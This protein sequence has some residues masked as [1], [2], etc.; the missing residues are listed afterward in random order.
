MTSS[1]SQLLQNFYFYK[2]RVEFIAQADV[3]INKW[4]HIKF[5]G[6]IG[7]LMKEYDE[8]LYLEVFKSDNLPAQLVISPAD[9]D[10]NKFFDGDSIT[11][12]FTL[13]HTDDFWVMKFFNFLEDLNRINFFGIEIFKKSFKAFRSI[14]GKDKPDQKNLFEFR[15]GF[16]YFQNKN[17]ELP[18]I[19][20]I[21]F[22]TPAT[23]RKN[24]L[25][26]TDISPEDL[27]RRIYKRIAGLYQSLFDNSF[28]FNF[29]DIEQKGKLVGNHLTF[30][31]KIIHQKKDYTGILGNMFMKIPPSQFTS[32]LLFIGSNLHIGNMTGG[33]NGAFSFEVAPVCKLHQNFRKKL[34]NSAE[35]V[36]SQEVIDRFENL[37]YIPFPMKQVKIPKS[38]G[39]FRNL[40]IPDKTD[41]ELQKIMAEVL[42]DFYNPHFLSQ[43]YAYQKGKSAKRAINQIQKWKKE[44]PEA[45]IVRCDID[46]FFDSIPINNLLSKL[47]FTSRDFKICHFIELWLRSA[48]VKKDAYAE[49]TEGIPQGS[50]L[51]PVLSNMYLHQLDEFINNRISPY[52]IRYADDIL[53][54]LKDGKNP[55]E[56]L[57]KIKDFIGAKLSL[58][59]NQ[60]FKIGT[61][62]DPFTFL[63][64]NLW[65]KNQLSVSEEKIWSM[66]GKVRNCLAVDGIGE[67]L[68]EHIIGLRRYYGELLPEDEI[69]R[70]D[71]AVFKVYADYCIK[72]NKKDKTPDI[73]LL[74]TNGLLN[75]RNT[76]LFNWEIL[77]QKSNSVITKT[78]K[79]KLEIQQKRN[80]K[81]VSSQYELVINKPGS[82]LGKNKSKIRV[83]VKGKTLS[84][85]PFSQIKHIC[86]MAPGVGLSS[87]VSQ[88]CAKK[89]I[90]ISFF[91]KV[92]ECYMVQH[93]DFERNSEIIELQLNLSQTRKQKF[94]LAIVKNKVNNQLKLLKYYNKYYRK[95]AEL[96]EKLNQKILEISDFAENELKILGDIPVNDLFI[97]EARA[98]GYYWQGF[99]ELVRHF[100]YPY[101]SREKKGAKDLVNQMLN[102][103][104]AILKN[105]VTRALMAEQPALN[106]GVLH[107]SSHREALV[108]D[109]MEQ[110][111]AFIADRAVLS[112]LSKNKEPEHDG[113]QMLGLETRKAIIEKINEYFSTPVK[114]EGRLYSLSDVMYLLSKYYIEYLKEER[115]TPKLYNP[116]W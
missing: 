101:K 114:F 46:N 59:L 40:E 21:K 9:S 14:Q 113:N 44:F 97:L 91:D 78:V 62:S 57:M 96:S 64:I 87:S 48:V 15:L 4:W 100:G 66:A 98:A 10:K 20:W 38:D 30:S 80:I 8:K 3:K 68:S 27:F 51:S 49:N 23:F 52:F 76:K 1:N 16:E 42:Y 50:P 83:T 79:E 58:Q 2:A 85:V 99:A 104:Y 94:A 77:T 67:K 13:I 102:Y 53:I 12:F 82:F 115:K 106:L 17:I 70:I 22:K 103:A 60:E 105:R 81:A 45:T 47:F 34:K 39:D 73:S 36:F 35:P 7:K 71:Q 33:G 72:L 75:P 86:I 109:M 90:H 84:Q 108:F 92:G 74:K 63:G 41:A 29:S 89:G 25:L 110:F 55:I 18:D 28:E 37:D 24:Q 65:G 56:K 69:Q 93:G 54:L 26:T 116:K 88:A 19:L 5:R 111:R 61:I 107:S 32:W 112:L 11:V 6:I 31:A 43:S 95:Q